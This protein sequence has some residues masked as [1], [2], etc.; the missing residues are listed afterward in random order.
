MSLQTNS[1]SAAT[2]FLSR[3]YELVSRLLLLRAKQTLWFC[4]QVRKGDLT[5][6]QDVT[7]IVDPTNGRLK[8]TGG[9]SGAI[10]ATAGPAC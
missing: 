9:V 4:P 6:V 2:V 1:E 7:A 5:G 8:A 3:K 10:K